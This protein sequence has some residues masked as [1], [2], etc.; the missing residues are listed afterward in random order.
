MATAKHYELMYEKI[1]QHINTGGLAHADE[2]RVTVA[3]KSCYVWIFTN[4]E[5][6]AFVYSESRE[7]RT[8]QEVL[9]GFQR[10]LVSDFYAGYD[11]IDCAQQKCLIHLMRDL[12]DDLH[13][14]PFN[15]EMKDI[16]SAFATLLQPMVKTIDRY[17]LKRRY[18]QKHKNAVKVF[19]DA[20]SKR[21]FHTE[22]AVGYKNRFERFQE[23]LF[24][25]IEHDGIP[26]NNNN[27]EHAVKAFVRL[28]NAIGGASTSKSI[29][30]YLVL[31]SVSETCKYKG[32]NFLDFL[33][34]DCKD[35]DD[36]AVGRK[37]R[38]QRSAS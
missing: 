25:F 11:S 30:E 24:T 27:A 6:A 17:G 19:F 1:L 23:K 4:Q 8:A 37:E 16:A 34:S 3:G 18:L 10:V 29:R 36:F 33:R 14:Q 35:I 22:V 9:R 28:R 26:W 32:I 20:L 31:L 5:E 15:E 21:D 38:R 13:K 7:A 2:T 12:N